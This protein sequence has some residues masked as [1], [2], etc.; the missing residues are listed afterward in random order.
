MWEKSDLK[1]IGQQE[2]KEA[3]GKKK[4]P[5]SS[6]LDPEEDQSPT[7][8]SYQ[9]AAAHTCERTHRG[10]RLNVIQFN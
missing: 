3:L 9:K 1:H 7:T 2:R 6:G 10:P 5:L 4:P 8:G